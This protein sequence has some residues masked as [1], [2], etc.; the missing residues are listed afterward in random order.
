MSVSLM[1]TEGRPPH[2]QFYEG[3]VEDRD[4][5]LREN[6]YIAKPVDYVII[7]QVGAKDDVEKEAVPWLESIGNNANYA[8]QWVDAFREAYKKWKAGQEITPIGTHVKV[9]AMI[10]KAQADTLISGGILTVEDLAAANESTLQRVGMGA[11]ELQYKARDWLAKATTIE[12][13]QKQSAEMQAKFDELQRQ[14]LAE[15]EAK[16]KQIDELKAMVA[17]LT[18]PKAETPKDDFLE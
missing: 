1:A 13:E 10:S 11:R 17:A 15:D 5:T 9:W 3:A 6:R 14:R 16:Q 8:P 7:R 4:A 18:A 12:K 2:I